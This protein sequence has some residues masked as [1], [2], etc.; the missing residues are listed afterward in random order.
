MVQ[1]RG[2]VRDAGWTDRE[3]LEID[4]AAYNRGEGP[5]KFLRG[6]AANAD[7]TARQRKLLQG[8]PTSAEYRGGAVRYLKVPERPEE[9]Y[10]CLV[11]TAHVRLRRTREMSELSYRRQVWWADDVPFGVVQMEDVVR[12]PIDNA[13]LSRVRWQLTRVSRR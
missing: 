8:V 1:S 11:G 4:L 13:I 12:D 3:R 9:A 7:E 10:R 6:A 5:D 2:G